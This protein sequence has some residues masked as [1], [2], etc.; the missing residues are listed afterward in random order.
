ML[1]AGSWV[2]FTL[3]V[4]NMGNTQDAITGGKPPSEVAPT[5]RFRVSSN[6]TTPW[7]RSPLTEIKANAVVTLRLEASSSHQERT[8]EVSIAVESEGD[9]NQRSAPLTSDVKLRK[10]QIRMP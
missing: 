8:C 7:C 4:S 5:S 10:L 9:N 6:S 1:F 3:E 2:E